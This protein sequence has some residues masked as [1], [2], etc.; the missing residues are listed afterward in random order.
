MIYGNPLPSLSI[1]ITFIASPYAIPGIIDTFGKGVC[2]S[3]NQNGQ[4][5]CVVN[6]P[7]YDMYRWTLQ[8]CDQVFVTDPKELVFNIRDA[9]NSS[10]K[11]YEKR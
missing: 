4:Y 3:Q 5:E 11:H 9:L 8:N 1:R 2:L 7:E 10:I 6:I